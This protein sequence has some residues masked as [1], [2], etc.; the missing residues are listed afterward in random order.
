MYSLKACKVSAHTCKHQCHWQNLD[1]PHRV[2]KPEDAMQIQAAA[3]K[4]QDLEQKLQQ[5]ETKRSSSSSSSNSPLMQQ[6]LAC[7]AR[8]RDD[9]LTRL[10]LISGIPLALKSQYYATRHDSRETQYR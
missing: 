1:C 7:L 9:A 8:E 10:D 6:R 5:G 3:Q 2:S 4:L